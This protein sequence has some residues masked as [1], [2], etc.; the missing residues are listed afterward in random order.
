MEERVCW[1]EVR[2][3]CVELHLELRDPGRAG[4]ELRARGGAT[5]LPP[6][7]AARM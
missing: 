1:W 4:A 6:T 3:R 5:E 7:G 2:L